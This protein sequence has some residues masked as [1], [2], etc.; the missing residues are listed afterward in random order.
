M[1]VGQRIAQK[2]RE[3]GLSQEE[4]GE[5][6]G[7]SRQAIYKWEADQ[8]LPEIE[9]LVNLSKLFS[10]P[11]GWLLGVEE[12]PSPDSGGE[13]TG[14]QLKMVEEIAKRYIDAIP[15]P[16]P[17]PEPEPP[18]KRRRW[19]FVVLT[20]VVLIGV[21]WH[22]FGRLDGLDNQYNSLQYS[23]GNVSDSVNRQING[24]ASRVESILEAQNTLV[25]DWKADRAPDYRA[26]EI[27]FT[28]R[29]VPK[30]YEEGMTAI[31][32]LESAG[33]RSETPAE[34]G[35]DHAF[36]GEVTCPLTDDIRLSV[37]FVSADGTRQTQ[38]LE[39]Y[40]MLYSGSFPSA[41]L[42]EG[43]LYYDILK[44][45]TLRADDHISY[46]ISTHDCAVADIRCGL[47][48]DNQLVTWYEAGSLSYPD[49]AP[50]PL[51]GATYFSRPQ[52]T[53]EQGHIYC[54]ALVITDEYGR[55]VVY[56]SIPIAWDETR[57]QWNVF[58][59]DNVIHVD[60]DPAHWGY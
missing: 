9:K 57:R 7:V 19:P 52:M 23:I 41:N 16:G 32:V 11:V 51:D 33:A 50:D 28:L 37:V 55:E 54:E 26:N 22:L 36:S 49:G 13:L 1:T 44:G 35:A 27:T 10:V 60:N 3:L 30:T 43:L 6:L 38:L 40:S 18:Q 42:A 17:A 14:E 56:P 8:T 20:A 47:F 45:D 46:S 59:P 21:F 48:R 24:I 58:A 34:P 4:L 12:E 25:A 39:Q 31:F 53:L 2:R 15:Q 29:A 5:R